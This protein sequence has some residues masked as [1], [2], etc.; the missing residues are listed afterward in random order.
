MDRKIVDVIKQLPESPLFLRGMIS[1]L[2][3]NQTEILYEQGLRE[4]GRSRIDHRQMVNLSISGITSFSIKPLRI[5]LYL[6]LL[7]ASFSIGYG[8]YAVYIKLFTPNSVDGWASL[9][10]MASFLGG[11]QM[12]MFGLLGEYLGRLFMSA[13]SRPSYI[14]R[15]TNFNKE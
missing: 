10:A 6:G 7:I 5:S 15:S 9:L 8:F 1:W 2:G 12:L 14:V 13:K 11:I 3:F 4:S